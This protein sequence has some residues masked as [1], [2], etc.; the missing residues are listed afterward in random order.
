[1]VIDERGEPAMNVHVRTLRAST[2]PG[3]GRFRQPGEYD[4]HLQPSRVVRVE[5]VLLGMPSDSDAPLGC[6][7]A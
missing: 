4:I 3:R 7:T 5:G 1:M 2:I 6:G